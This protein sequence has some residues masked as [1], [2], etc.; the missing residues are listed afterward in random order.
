MIK[1]KIDT[2]NGNLEIGKRYKIEYIAGQNNKQGT[3]EFEGTLIKKMDKYYIF[4][5]ILGYKECFLKVD[6]IIGEYKIKEVG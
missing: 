5:S 2:L 3:N 1:R 6:F 4:K